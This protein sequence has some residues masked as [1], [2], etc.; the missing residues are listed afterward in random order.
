MTPPE[1]MDIPSDPKG[2]PE[3]SAGEEDNKE[4]SDKTTSSKSFRAGDI[5]E[6]VTRQKKND[7][8]AQNIKMIMKV[9]EGNFQRNIATKTS[10]PGG[11]PRRWRRMNSF[12]IEDADPLEFFLWSD[13]ASP[14]LPRVQFREREST[15]GEIAILRD[16]STSMMGTYSEWASSVVRGVIELARTKNMRCGYLEFNHKADPYERQKGKRSIFSREYPWLMDMAESTDCSGNTNYE[17]ALKTIVSE[18]KGR[19]R[20]N[21][22]IL[23]I[24]DGIPTSGDIRLEDDD[25]EARRRAP[26]LNKK[27]ELTDHLNAGAPNRNTKA[28]RPLREIVKK[29]QQL[30]IRIH[31]I[32]IGS[33]NYPPILQKISEETFGAQFVAFRD[34]EEIMQVERKDK[35]ISDYARKTEKDESYDPIKAAFSHKIH[36]ITGKL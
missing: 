22:H 20:R 25:K 17:E 26:L 9:L 18:F 19:G 6:N 29:T 36:T 14:T 31:S 30:G 3:Q 5:D 16:V 32:F 11:M 28:P 33:K 12:D 13:T 10:H 23:F 7:E 1:G 27:E 8:T 35:F 4:L 34:N 15:G 24:T 21:K 2:Q